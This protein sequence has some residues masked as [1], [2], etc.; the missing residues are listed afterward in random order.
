MNW[1][2]NLPDLGLL[3]LR[4]GPSGLMMTHGWPKMNSML[5]Q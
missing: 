1:T 5:D 2:K 4:A 3:V